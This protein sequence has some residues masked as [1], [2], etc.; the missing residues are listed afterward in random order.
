MNKNIN[1]S[2][3]K[4]IPSFLSYLPKSQDSSLFL[5]KTS[6]NEIIGIIK[7]LKNGKSSEIP[8]NVIKHIK[9]IIAPHLSKL[10][11]SC[12][13]QGTFPPS[14]KTG[15]ITPIHKKGPKNDITNY[16]PASTLPIF[17]KIFEKIIYDRLYFFITA[18]K[19]LSP[20]QFGFRK[21]YST[22]HAVNHSIDLIKN[23][24]IKVKYTI[25]IL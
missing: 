8:I 21:M 4:S 17:G 24:Q 20:T 23:F 2:N 13:A 22:S 5:S 16:R 1:L 9:N 6:G 15:R 25:G 14:L 7:E 11:N 3:D 10:F 12:M 19:I 18:R